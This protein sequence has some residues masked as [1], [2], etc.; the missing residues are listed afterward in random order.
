MVGRGLCLGGKCE[1][2]QERR[3]SLR[4]RC[5]QATSVLEALRENLF[6]CFFQLLPATHTSWLLAPSPICIA[7]SGA[8]L[9]RGPV[10][11]H[12]A[13]GLTTAGKGSSLLRARPWWYRVRPGHP[14]H[15]PR[16]KILHRNHM[17]K[18]VSM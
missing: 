8:A 3:V 6:P 2:M 12:T 14:G 5:R 17:A 18:P 7:S 11:S 10:L 16:G 9:H 13:M 15:S 4:G 1:V